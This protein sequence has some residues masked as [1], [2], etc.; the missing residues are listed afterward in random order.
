MPVGDLVVLQGFG[1]DL[2]DGQLAD[3]VLSWSSSRQ[4]LLGTGASLPITTLQ[5]GLHTITLTATDSSNQT[6][7]VS[8][9]LFIGERVYLPQ[10]R[11]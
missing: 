1:F 6:A 10:A 8:V 2:E 5:P 11:R 9:Q 3:S 4:G 7:S